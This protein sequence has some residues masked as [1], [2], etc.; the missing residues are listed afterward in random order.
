MAA[1]FSTLLVKVATYIF[2]TDHKCNPHCTDN[3]GYAPLHV[4]SES[5]NNETVKYLITEQGCQPQGG[6]IAVARCLIEEHQCSPNCTNMFGNTSLHLA[7]LSSC[8]PLVK[9][10]IDEHVCNPQI[11][12]NDGLT[13]LHYACSKW[14]P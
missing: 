9:C 7:C 1:H 4:A 14:T 13:P 10:L 11:V 12:N 3:D 2:I 6:Q 8:L 5:G